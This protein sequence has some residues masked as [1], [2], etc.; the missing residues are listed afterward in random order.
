MCEKS[1]RVGAPALT[2]KSVLAGVAYVH[3][4]RSPRNNSTVRLAIQQP[5]LQRR[6]RVLPQCGI[7]LLYRAVQKDGQQAHRRQKQDTHQEG[8]YSI[9]AFPNQKSF[10]GNLCVANENNF[11]SSRRGRA[12]PPVLGL[13]VSHGRG[14]RRRRFLGSDEHV[15]I[16]PPKQSPNTFQIFLKSPQSSRH[17]VCRDQ[18]MTMAI[19]WHVWELLGKHFLGR[20]LSARSGMYSVLM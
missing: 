17:C 5:S 12:P 18:T 1:Q 16:T 13:D 11:F 7:I 19:P 10:K 2:F 15:A 6:K 20:F 3:D 8:Q 14:A 4:A 9:H